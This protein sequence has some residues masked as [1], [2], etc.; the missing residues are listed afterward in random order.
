MEFMGSALTLVAEFPD[1]E[2]A[3]PPPYFRS[4]NLTRC[5]TYTKPVGTP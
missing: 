5:V 4:A 3:M 1:P 2:T